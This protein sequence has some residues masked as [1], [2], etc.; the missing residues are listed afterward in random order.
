MSIVLELELAPACSEE[1]AKKGS[2]AA[3]KD[4][5]L[6]SDPAPNNP[7]AAASELLEVLFLATSPT[8]CKSSLPSLPTR[9]NAQNQTCNIPK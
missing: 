6:N 8:I 7:A 5:E 9:K 3:N 2:W 4:G 1:R